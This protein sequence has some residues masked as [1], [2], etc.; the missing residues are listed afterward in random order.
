VLRLSGDADHQALARG[1]DGLPRDVIQDIDLHQTGNLREEAVEQSE[2]LPVIR[3]IAATTSSL[4]NPSSGSET[5]G[6][7]QFC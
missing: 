4:A 5:P 7:A 6:G 1:L 2:V 3:I